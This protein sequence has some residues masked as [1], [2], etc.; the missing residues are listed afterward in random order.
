MALVAFPPDSAPDSAVRQD[1]ITNP[2]LDPTFPLPSDPYCIVSIRAE[3]AFTY[4]QALMHANSGHVGGVR[5][6]TDH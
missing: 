5:N 2:T 4:H 6:R 3:F 1:D